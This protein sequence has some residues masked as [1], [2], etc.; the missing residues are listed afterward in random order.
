MEAIFTVRVCTWNE[1]MLNDLETEKYFNPF[2][3]MTLP[4]TPKKV[5]K[6]DE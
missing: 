2:V 1:A 5:P 3:K 6:N 4:V